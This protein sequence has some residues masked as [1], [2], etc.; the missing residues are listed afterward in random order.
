MLKRLSSQEYLGEDGNAPEGGEP[1]RKMLRY[2]RR[3][4]RLSRKGLETD[5]V[6]GV[7]LRSLDEIPDVSTFCVFLLFF[8]PL[9][10]R[11]PC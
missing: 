1:R 4:P 11:S 5:A 2:G 9:F 10:L 6:T 3:V 8:S 7:R